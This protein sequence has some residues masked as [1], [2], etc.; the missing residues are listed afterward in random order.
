MADS[1]ETRFMRKMILA[2]GLFLVLVAVAVTAQRVSALNVRVSLA[3]TSLEHF[4]YANVLLDDLGRERSEA[5]YLVTLEGR[6]PDEYESQ[7]DSTGSIMSAL[8]NAV[9][10]Q[11]WERTLSQSGQESIERTRVAVSALGALRED[12]RNGTIPADAV[13]TRYGD[14]IDVLIA[15]MGLL[16]HDRLGESRFGNAFV[17]LATLDDRIGIENALGQVA[18]TRGWL[19][20]ALRDEFAQSIEMQQVQRTQ[21]HVTT[22][23]ASASAL[24]LAFRRTDTA[25]LTATRNALL[26]SS[27]DNPLLDPS[28]IVAWSESMRARHNDL[29]TLRRL[30]LRA[31]IE[32]FEAATRTR[33]RA[34]LVQGLGAGVLAL[35]LMTGLLAL[36]ER[37]ARRGRSAR[38]GSGLG[39]GPVAPA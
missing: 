14:L 39:G 26:G 38:R 18:F 1:S 9:S 20:D 4:A 34:A 5:I 12:V 21:Y 30:R 25:E 11:R 2:I 19:P 17:A 35:I 37:R 33:M 24:N 22:D 7:I 28:D 29:S 10:D 23:A 8:S 15:E 31:E 13:I 3:K 6:T 27:G 32:T 16:N 36:E